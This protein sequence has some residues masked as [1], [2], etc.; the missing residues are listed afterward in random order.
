MPDGGI[1]QMTNDAHSG[2]VVQ[3]FDI[4]EKGIEF[5]IPS[6]LSTG[7]DFTHKGPGAA[8]FFEEVVD[9]SL[10]VASGGF[11]SILGFLVVEGLET[12][13]VSLLDSR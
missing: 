13:E 8:S 3:S 1:T 10:F 5:A 7:I 9:F 6:I 11:H 2:L 4:A 12:L